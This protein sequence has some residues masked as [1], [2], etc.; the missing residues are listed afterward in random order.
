MPSIEDN[1]NDKGKENSEA[2]ADIPGA[3]GI[4]DATERVEKRLGNCSIEVR[5]VH[6]NA[7]LG[8]FCFRWIFLFEEGTSRRISYVQGTGSLL[9]IV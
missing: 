6:C 5:L 8:L 9:S 2:M 3:W 4:E 7:Q 1:I